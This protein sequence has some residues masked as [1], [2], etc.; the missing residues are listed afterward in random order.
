M[1]K[2]YLSYFSFIVLVFITSCNK[3][4]PNTAMKFSLGDEN[5]ICIYLADQLEN[6]KDLV[7]KEKLVDFDEIIGYDPKT[8]IFLVND[9]AAERIRNNWNKYTTYS[10]GGA[11]F[12]V[13]ASD[14]IVYDGLIMT[15]ISSCL[16]TNKICFSPF[17]EE[18][19]IEL[20]LGYPRTF[21]FNGTDSRNDTRLI[22]I[23]ERFNKIRTII[24]ANRG[25]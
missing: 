19:K 18:D 24:P 21:S 16:V 13:T 7:L 15:P 23:L 3:E 11:S 9:I 10:V 25:Y 1:K 22:S 17:V 8:Y 20:E 2:K 6:G 4:S 5:K 14:E 12:V